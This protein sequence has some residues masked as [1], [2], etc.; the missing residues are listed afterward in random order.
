M[1]CRGPAAIRRAVACLV[2]ALPAGCGA[3]LVFAE[4]GADPRPPVAESRPHAVTA[5]H[6]DTRM[7]PYYWLRDRDDPG[8]LA[9]LRAEN[10]YAEAAMAATRDLRERLFREIRGR[11]LETDMSV[12][13]REGSYW[14]YTRFEEGQDH[15]IYARRKGSMDAPE[16]VILDAN[17]RAHG[18]SYYRVS[19]R[20]SSGEDIL[21]FAED[22]TGR[23]VV[24]IRFKDLDTG[25]L[26]DDVI[27]DVSWNMAWAED[28]RTLFYAARDPQTLR[29]DRIF[30]HRLGIDPGRAVL[31]HEEA[32]ATFST[33]VYRTRSRE[34]LVIGSRHRLTNEYRYVPADQPELPLRLFSP[35]QRGHEHEI[36]H[37]GDYFYIRT[38]DGAR[39]FRLMR[40]P[41]GRT[42][43]ENWED[44]I[45]HREDVLV[46]GFELFR[47]HLVVMERANGQRRIRVRR[48]SG[49][50]DHLIGFDEE[51]YTVYPERNPE[52]E[53]NV[54]RIGYESPATPRSTHDYDM[55]RREL[56]LLKREEVLGGHDPAEY[57]TERK[58]VAAR[59]GT[60]VPVTLVYRRELRDDGPQPLL[61]HAY[62]A[63]GASSDP[64]F[65][66]DRLSLLD[67]GMVHA[68]AHVRGGQEL[69]RDWYD[70]GRLLNKRNSFHDFIDV[71]E[72]LV[73][74]GYTSPDQLLIEGRSAGGLLIG[75]VINMRPDL[76]HGALAHVPFVDVVTSMLDDS[77][78]LTTGEYDEW[79]DPG[80]P[81]HYAYML[82][83]SP[84]DNVTGQDY[85]HLLMTSGLYDSQVQFWEPAK[86]AAKLR[87][88][89]TDDNLLLLRTRM[90]AGHG[91]AAGRYARWRDTA[92]EY[93]FILDVAG[94]GDVEPAGATARVVP[95]RP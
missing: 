33:H 60:R 71:A 2:G 74:A 1:S 67:R 31:V 29:A 61:L 84:Y 7:D 83:Y 68:I 5:P 46:H 6:G 49:D 36:D 73:A 45:P 24:T 44:V 12:P 8:V 76:F 75:A 89:K 35:R 66:P 59:D 56:R 11:V 42:A 94:L 80:N 40:T 28:N 93:A 91:G 95:P 25:E 70:D 27:R 62:G 52:F 63:Y 57:R 85:P 13:Y 16:E 34:Y 14:Y 58:M 18:H 50:D 82:S 47:D 79:G 81:V 21:A 23:N 65:S 69:G 54:L 17:A 20:V 55:D 53:T 86:W 30:R 64:R 37:A 87:A 72:E 78:P 90:D 22:T 4:P 92:F 38:N 88:R 77:M 43:R 51:A 9:Y 3:G 10:E 32:D 26:L 19:W 15:P 41:V 39:N 48:W